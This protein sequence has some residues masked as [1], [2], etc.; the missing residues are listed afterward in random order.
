[1]LT[2]SDEREEKASWFGLKGTIRYIPLW[3]W[4]LEG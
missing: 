2:D 1:M 3:R 4:L